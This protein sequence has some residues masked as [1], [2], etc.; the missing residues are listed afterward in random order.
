MSSVISFQTREGGVAELTLQDASGRVLSSTPQTLSAGSHDWQ[1][2]A[3]E[4]PGVYLL[5]LTTAGGAQRT[6]RWV[7]Q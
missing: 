2:E 5:R 4:T 1:V 7:I 3:P 6:W